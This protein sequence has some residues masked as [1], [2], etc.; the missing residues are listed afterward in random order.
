MLQI[1]HQKYNIAFM[2]TA[3]SIVIFLT[4]LMMPIY[5]S[6]QESFIIR[7]YTVG[8]IIV[9]I[10]ILGISAIF[11]PQECTSIIGQKRA[12]IDLEVGNLT[13]YKNMFKISKLK[14]TH[15]HHPPCK[16]F[17][18]HEFRLGK[19]TFCAGCT[20]MLMGTMISLIGTVEYFFLSWSFPW[21]SIYAVVLGIIGVNLGL[22]QFQ[23]FKKR[24]NYHRIFL[25]AILI[26]GMFL[27][28]VGVDSIVQSVYVDI[29]LI[30][31]FI[32]LM[33]ARILFSCKDHEKTCVTCG[34]ACKNN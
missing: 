2:F 7:M 33:A 30:L 31:T 28:L 23:L 20:G 19:R 29:S 18:D 27:L 9:I 22:F 26:L 25:N 12:A 13:L 8:S 1:I 10:C 21:H 17:Y 14:L 24:R 3:S 16:R 34:F 4:I 15:G 32:F 5:T 11:I 6:P